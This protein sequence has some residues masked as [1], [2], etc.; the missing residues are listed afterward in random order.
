MWQPIETAPKDGTLVLICERGGRRQ[1]A[2]WCEG[3]WGAPP[4]WWV[5]LTGRGPESYP[6]LDVTHW[7]PLPPPPTDNTG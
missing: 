3:D 6:T 2:K 7:M 4:C 5:Q 1:V